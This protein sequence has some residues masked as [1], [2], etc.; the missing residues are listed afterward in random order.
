VDLRRHLDSILMT[1]TVTLS[2][3]GA[4]RLSTGGGGAR[5]LD[6]APDGTLWR[7]YRLAGNMNFFYSKDGGKSW[8][9]TSTSTTFNGQ[10]THAGDFSLF[11]D[12]D[13]YMHVAYA[14]YNAGGN[15]GRTIQNAVIYRRGT[16]T[17][18]GTGWSWSGE[19]AITGQDFW[20]CPQVVAH[21]EGTGW[22]VHTLTAYNWAGDNRSILH[23]CRFNV[24]AAGAIT[25][26]TSTFLHDSPGS[27]VYHS[28]PSLE[29]R[30]NGDG[31]TPQVIGGAAKPDLFMCWTSSNVLHW[32]KL[33]YLGGGNWGNFSYTYS[34]PSTGVG[35]VQASSPYMEGLYQHHRWAKMLY[36]A[37]TQRYMFVG[38][39]S[40]AAVTAQYLFCEEWDANAAN[41]FGSYQAGYSGTSPYFYSGNA[42]L[43]PDGN[44]EVCGVDVWSP[45]NSRLARVMVRRPAGSNT[46]TLLDHQV[47]ESGGHSDPNV[48]MLHYPKGSVQ[49]LFNRGGNVYGAQRSLS[50]LWMNVGG[51][52]KNV[53]RYRNVGGTPVPVTIKK[54]A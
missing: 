1:Y 22:K 10:I 32:G 3:G 20:H 27:T 17:G 44:V 7:A 8:T 18:G 47:V 28:H 43:L 37:T 46:R 25:M 51:V 50:N 31:K 12:Q 40:N 53:I 4:D 13:G 42:A 6:V 19:V 36:D 2:E 15:D 34:N 52:A 5:H 16:P 48:S 49:L 30:H 9:W 21:R 54:G 38:M 35:R 33:S 11:I 26:D 45:P 14:R 24:T 23:Y 39:L 29:F 41:H